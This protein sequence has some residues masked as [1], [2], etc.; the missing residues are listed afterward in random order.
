MNESG[1]ASVRNVCFWWIVNWSI[2]KLFYILGLQRHF[3][4][5]NT[6]HLYSFFLGQTTFLH[7]LSHQFAVNLRRYSRIGSVI[8][9]RIQTE[10]GFL[11]LLKQKVSN[12]WIKSG[13]R[14]YVYTH[15]HVYV[16]LSAAVLTTDSHRWNNV[17]VG[18]LKM[19]V[20]T[21]LG[22]S[23]CHPQPRKTSR[24]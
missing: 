17:S 10:S 12:D 8:T 13:P 19:H 20:P 7:W 1:N 15:I 23:P 6:R 9:P 22:L 18:K 24:Q 16:P 3:L 21:P 5:L 2:N 11:L 14:L 4:G